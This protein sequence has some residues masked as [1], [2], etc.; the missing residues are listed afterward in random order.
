MKKKIIVGSII[1][2]ALLLLMPSIPAIQQTT[3]V[4]NDENIQDEYFVFGFLPR[5]RRNVLFYWVI[6]GIL[7]GSVWDFGVLRTGFGFFVM[8]YTTHKPTYQFG[9][10]PVPFHWMW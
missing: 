4:E 10:I 5:E 2:V 7:Y 9:S 8:G 3:S 1:A 6:P